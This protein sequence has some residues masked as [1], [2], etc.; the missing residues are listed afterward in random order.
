[1]SIAFELRALG[2]TGINV[3]P[4]GMSAS[5]Y[6][7]K[8]AVW[9]AVDRGVNLFFAF[10][11]DEQMIRVMRELLP[12]RRDEFVIVTGAYNYM[13]RAQDVHKTLEKRLRQF[14]TDRIDVFLFLGVMKPGDFTMKVRE[15]LSTLKEGQKV[16]S[17]SVS[18]HNRAFLGKL[19]TEGVVDTLMRRYNAAHRGAELD[20]FPHLYVHKPGV[21]GYTA[22]RWALLLRRPRDWPENGRI[23]TAGECYRFALSNPNVHVVLAAPRNERQLRENIAEVEKGPMD[24]DDMK[25]IREFGEAVHKRKKWFM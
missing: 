2:A 6:P 13:W 17:I 20:V 3:T 23:P 12:S 15:E 1:M 16:R 8:K 21:I 5:Y 18:C 10:G 7:G 24:E 9:A 25:F 19:A 4:L 14:N 22:T 11:F